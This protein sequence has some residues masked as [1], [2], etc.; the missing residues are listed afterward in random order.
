MKKWITKGVFLMAV[1][2]LL[3]GCLE[4]LL[5]SICEEFL[6]KSMVNVVFNTSNPGD[7]SGKKV[8]ITYTDSNNDRFIVDECEGDLRGSLAGKFSGQNGTDGFVE[9]SIV[10]E[11]DSIFFDENGD[12]IKGQNALYDV[13]I[14]W[15]NDC[16]TQTAS[17]SFDYAAQQIKWLSQITRE[18]EAEDDGMDV[19]V[20]DDI[21]QCEIGKMGL[22]EVDEPE[23]EETDEAP[24][25]EN[26]PAEDGE[27][28]MPEDPQVP[29]DDGL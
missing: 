6:D 14:K 8:V 28:S 1:P 20:S 5:E 9:Y 7:Y 16:N 21:F 2:V 11:E 29:P 19:D 23:A 17:H 3:T 12:L 15:Y 24:V 22:F 4:K 10:V 25:T 26:P 18:E 13:N 27:P